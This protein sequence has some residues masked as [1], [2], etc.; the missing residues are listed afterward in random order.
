MWE[1][2]H[3]LTPWWRHINNFHDNDKIWHMSVHSLTLKRDRRPLGCHERHQ[4]ACLEL[5]SHYF[6]SFLNF[7]L[8]ILH[9]IF[10]SPRSTESNLTSLFQRIRT[11]EN[12]ELKDFNPLLTKKEFKTCLESKSLKKTWYL[13]T[14]DVF[15]SFL[16]RVCYFVFCF[17]LFQILSIVALLIS[18]LIGF[19]RR[20]PLRQ[21]RWWWSTERLL[22]QLRGM[23]W[24]SRRSC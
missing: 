15:I 2:N 7:C 3:R 6:S 18:C 14:L 9:L 20:S 24:R 4:L 21:M 1:V 16:F 13:V 11:F 22:L 12:L 19:R 10:C 17:V 8:P 23:P 5:L